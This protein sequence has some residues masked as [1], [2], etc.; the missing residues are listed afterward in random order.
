MHVARRSTSLCRWP[1][2]WPIRPW[3]RAARAWC[4][5]FTWPIAA[6]KAAPA[7]NSSR[8]LRSR[9]PPS[10][11][12]W[13]PCSCDQTWCRKAAACF[14]LDRRRAGPG[15]ARWGW[16][17]GFLEHGKGGLRQNAA[18]SYA[19][20]V[21]GPRIGIGFAYCVSHVVVSR[22]APEP[23]AATIPLFVGFGYRADRDLGRRTP[24]SCSTCRRAWPTP[25]PLSMM[26]LR[27]ISP[28]PSAIS[29]SST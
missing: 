26:N 24:R 19:V 29:I 17:A 14:R 22:R 20:S 27:R 23:R 28:L 5:W 25:W 10:S 4:C 8:L 13:R 6:G 21:N 9:A 15:P 2:S 1:I 12:D 3:R 18:N 11:R 16:C 7:R